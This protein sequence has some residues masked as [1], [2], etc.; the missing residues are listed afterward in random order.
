MLNWLTQHSPLLYLTQSIWR[1][2]AFS[3]LAAQRPLSFIFNNLGVEPPLYYVLLH[4]WIKLFGTSEIAV[5]SLSFLG[6]ALATIVVIF[7]A[8][9]LFQKHFLSWYLPVFFFINPMLLYYAFEVRTYGWFMFFG[10]LS[11]YGYSE[12]KWWVAAVANILGF[13]THIYMMFVPIAQGLHWLATKRF[14]VNLSWLKDQTLQSFLVSA[15]FMVPW[16]FR[17][18]KEMEKLKQTWYF[19]VDLHLV[20]SVLGNMFIG[21]EGTPWFLWNATAWLSLGLLALFLFSLT[22]KTNRARNAYFLTMIILPLAIVIGVSF[23]KPLFVNRYLIPV[24]IAEVFLVTFAI[25]TMNSKLLQYG[26]ATV[27]LLAVL[28]FN[29]WYP[30]KHAKLNIRKTLTEINMLRGKQDIILAGSPLIFFESIY[31]SGDPKRVFLYNP[32]NIAFPAYVGDA[33]VTPAQMIREI[34]A[35]P[36]RAFLIHEDGTFE[37]TYTL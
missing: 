16:F 13:Y 18:A 14:K 2:E 20:Q 8:E 36:A 29:L 25:Q 10:V 24:A 19:P 33:L 21:Y 35:Y 7:W 15:I 4:F 32:S 6:F 9:K 26:A 28:L 12:K 1:D 17:V 3:I 5:R 30:T 31:Y 37:I 22:S 34:P 23:F 27:F 11:L